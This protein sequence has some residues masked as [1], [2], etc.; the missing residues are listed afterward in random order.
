MPWNDYEIEIESKYIPGNKGLN[1]PIWWCSE[2][3][4]GDLEIFANNN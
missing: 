3:T 1:W 2:L 4:P